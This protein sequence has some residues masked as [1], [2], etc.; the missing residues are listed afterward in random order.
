VL[1]A[2]SQAWASWK[3]APGIALLAVVAF[4]VGI[5]SATAI[6]TVVNGVLLRPLPYPDGERFVS[7]YGV[8]TTNPG[9]FNLMSVPE[10]QAYQQ[11]TTSFDVF[12]WL[13]TGRYLL[14]A[15]GEPRFV[16]GA[17]V[18]PALARQLG[19]PL[20][21]QWF[22]DD[23][24]AVISSTLWR[25]LGG[26]REIIGRVIT[27]DERQYTISGVMP[28]TFQL[29]L[30][31]LGISRG[32]TEVWIPLDPSPPDANR[33]SG[34]N[35]A[36][37]RRKPGVSLEQAQAD[38]RRSATIVAA[39]DP[40]RYQFYTADAADLR[41]AT[42]GLVGST[43]RAPL[44]ILLGAA[45]LLLLI[46]C[47]NV[48]TL[49][50]ARSVVRARETA[51]RVALGASR[52]QLA[53]RYFAEGALVSVAGAA[54]GVGLS[55]I[56]VRQMLAAAS[57]FIPRIDDIA[58]D[59]KVLGFS[60]AVAITTG[61]LAGL[62]PLWQ[63]IRT[64]PSAVL[65]EGVRASAG[66]PA[67]RLS[68]AFVVAEIALAFALLTTSAILVVHM[69]NLERVSLGFDPDGLVAFNL[70]LPRGAGTSE[71]RAEQR[72]AAQTRLMDALRQTPGVTGAAFASQ[73][74]AG[75]FCGGTAIYIEG[76]PRD[77]LGQR[78]C[79]VGATPDF[80]ST[81]RIPLRAGRLL[82]ESDSQ[83]RDAPA[84]VINE[85][86]ARAYWPGRD[87]IGASARLSTPDNDRFEIV[88]VVGDVRNNGFY[89]P[90]APEIYVPAAV[91]GVNPM[92]VVVRSDLPAD[93]LIAAVRRTVRQADPTLV[94]ENVRT[95]HDIVLN[96]LQLERLSSLVM[97]FFGLAA[98]VMATLGIY[99]VVSYFVRQ[100]TVELGTRMALGA[101]NRD[102]VAL[103]VGGGLKLSLAGVAVGSIA[104]V[105]GVWL[106]IR[107]LEVANFGSLPFAASTAV[108]TLVAAGAASV[109]AWRTTLLSPMV[110]IRE[111][112]PSVWRWTREGMQRAVRDLH[113]AVDGDGSGS[114]V[115]PANMLTAF[116]AAARGAD[117]YT[118][119]LRAALSS[120]CA[121]LGVESAALL[122]RHDGSPVDYRCLIA[123]G[124][125]DAAAPVV[126]ADGFL[127]TRL[128]AYPLPLPFAPD[129][130]AALAAWAAAH[131]PDR[132]DEIRALAAGGVR[133]AVPLRTRSEILGVLLLGER[134]FDSRALAQGKPQRASFSAHE[135]QVLRACADQFA[136]MI[137]NARLT[138]RVVEQETLRRDIALASDVQRR[139]L[140]DAPPRAEC[141]DFAAVSVPARRIGGDYYDFLELGD[142]RIGIALADVSGK[143]VPAALI[144]SV[145]QASLRII[146]SGGDVPPARLVAVI[147]Q[148]VYRS[149]PA[150]KYATFF[151]AQLDERRRELRYVNAGHNPPYL[152][153]AGRRSTAGS[154]PS[155]IEELSA[156]GMVVG[157][158]PEME[159]EEATVTLCPDDVLLAYTDGVT[160]AHNPEDEEFGEERLQQ[161]LRQ[162]AHLPVNE[163]S[164]RLS[165][166]MKDWI[167]DAEQYDDL[168]FIVMKVR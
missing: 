40:Q 9:T 135:K 76:R 122:E 81:M 85:A 87:P 164:A 26:G 17:A 37:A 78:V 59:W 97:T 161:L 15:P 168:T 63:A 21:G 112:P 80:F 33:G 60:V 86:A 153:R 43:V 104:L 23:T 100:R 134:S 48:A 156:G 4:A 118:G 65:S 101:V 1:S 145:V 107:Y 84:V 56:L 79:P 89:R 50:L 116:V 133:L 136:L 73:L 96:T 44:L 113:Q 74:P 141:A 30:A 93:Q 94:M 140:P 13:R 47:A 41:E 114:D 106:L 103:V 151:Y 34:N 157:M 57:G 92:N 24:S 46:A 150:N 91:L 69:R 154:A 10:L 125:L 2:F 142:G 68:K 120:V 36:Y 99:G 38:V 49:L 149:T 88:G 130:L 165:D 7:L 109:P 90:A 152:L 67:R 83:Q 52:R 31:S 64:P 82:N 72:R 124:A 123:A 29:P 148:F 105:G 45:G 55:V 158:F 58:I 160:E 132:L 8:N 77:A 71:E 98:L 11:Q 22:S 12:G 6:F 102:L 155:E 28:P 27:L 111:Q 75:P 126:A 61:V 25:R 115:S 39:T 139:L 110:A 62:A 147:N 66:A 5:G 143:G 95:I 108:V 162:T 14:T 53:L 129:D 121:E 3:S 127:I 159:Y 119:A 19:P 42:I 138:D 117:S 167:R 54:A 16:P 51:I 128:R 35:V 144:M 20:F 70:T 32:D 18:T 137:E 146:S 131:R 166:Q 163:I